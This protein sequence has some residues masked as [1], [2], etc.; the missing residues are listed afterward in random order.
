MGPGDPTPG[1]SY[2]EP[3]RHIPHITDLDG[4]EAGS[5][6]PVLAHCSAAL[7]QATECEHIYIYVF[8][9]GVPHL[10]LHLAPH[11]EGDALSANMLRGEVET[12][13]TAQGTTAIVSKDF[14]SIDQ[15]EL[16][17]VAQRVADL[18]HH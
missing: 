2:L 4:A 16:R 6:G 10:H 11:V 1:F 3:R 5:L 13:T 14:P 18:L 17:R 9:G 12:T 7:K 15:G 8:G